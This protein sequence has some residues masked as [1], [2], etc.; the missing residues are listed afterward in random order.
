MNTLQLNAV[1]GKLHNT[2][3]NINFLGVYACD[4]LPAT[5]FL[6]PASLIVNTDPSHGSGE[7]WLA[8]FITK[9]NV[10]YFFDSF[11]NKPHHKR[12]PKSIYTFLK[13]RCSSV[14]YSSRQIQDYMSV[15]CGEHCVYFLYN[16]SRGVTYE[17]LMSSYSDSFINND[18]KVLQFVKKIQTGMF[19]F[20]GVLQCVQCCTVCF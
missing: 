18:K 3:H 10:G 20:K 13:S 11:G 9:D 5:D 19:R 16:M 7:H 6:K 8:V 1:M 15:T 4:Q 14:Q 17:C 2:Y 12:F